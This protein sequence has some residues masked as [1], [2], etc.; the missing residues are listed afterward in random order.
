MHYLRMSSSL[1]G[2]LLASA[3]AIAGAQELRGAH[4]LSLDGTIFTSESAKVTVGGDTLTYSAS[5]LGLF[6][7][8]LGAGYH[9]GVG[10]SVLLGAHVATARSAVEIQG[11]KAE[12][13]S[14]WLMPEVSI[15]L[16]DRGAVRPFLTAGVGL[17]QSSSASDGRTLWTWTSLAAGATGGV[18]LFA[19]P[20]FSIDPHVGA[21]YTSGSGDFGGDGVQRTSVVL[22][23]GVSL[24]GWLGTQPSPRAPQD[25]AP[26]FA[27]EEQAA[28][29]SLAPP[30]PRTGLVVPA[31]EG[32]QSMRLVPGVH[33]TKRVRVILVHPG[34]QDVIRGCASMTLISGDRRVEVAAER[35]RAGNTG[36]EQ[37]LAAYVDIGALA[38]DTGIAAEACGEQWS[39][40]PEERPKVDQLLQRLDK[41]G[42]P[43][44]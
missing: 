3:P 11:T 23:A 36:S 18:H 43:R 15:L 35:I 7:A 28:T 21:F 17:A 30:P 26:G 9:Y 42:S 34:K 14:L 4:R 6:G 31:G 41:E 20:T 24:S 1:L 29:P 39:T 33:G 40:T 25:E 10:S 22:L 5:S 12:Q 32:G 8:G 16:T 13:S 38:G 37:A 19:T 2:L 44:R 27:P